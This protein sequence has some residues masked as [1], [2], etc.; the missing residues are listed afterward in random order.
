MEICNGDYGP[1]IS[2]LVESIEN[3][4]NDVW[5]LTKT[6][7]L[8]KG[9]ETFIPQQV[10]KRL[11]SFETEFR[12]TPRYTANFWSQLYILIKRNAIRLFRDK[13]ILLYVTN[14]SYKYGPDVRVITRVAR[15]AP[16]HASALSVC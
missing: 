12:N 11:Y 14:L 4:K 1:H 13:V 7:Y 2:K 6:V 3:G 5:R 15:G 8:N 10:A 16:L 9:K